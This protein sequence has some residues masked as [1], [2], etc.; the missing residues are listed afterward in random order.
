M[1][2]S[3]HGLASPISVELS[4]VSSVPGC[5]GSSSCPVGSQVGACRQCRDWERRRSAVKSE[6]GSSEFCGGL[7]LLVGAE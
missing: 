3:L 5:R 7:D 4:H 2:R 6:S 1:T